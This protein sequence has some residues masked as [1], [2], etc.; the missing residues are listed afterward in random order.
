MKSLRTIILVIVALSF[1]AV[2]LVFFQVDA[3]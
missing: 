1:L 3:T 2:N